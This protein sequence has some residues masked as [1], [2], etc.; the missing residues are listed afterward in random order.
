MKC[1]QAFFIVFLGL[2]LIPMVIAQQVGTPGSTGLIPKVK[3]STNIIGQTTDLTVENVASQAQRIYILIGARSWREQV[4]QFGQGAWLMVR[5]EL[6]LEMQPQGRLS[7]PVVGGLPTIYVQAAVIDPG[8]QGGIA[9]SDLFAFNIANA[10]NRR[11]GDLPQKLIGSAAAIDPRTGIMYIFG[12][13]NAYSSQ[14]PTDKII[15]M[16]P[17]QSLGH[18]VEERG[19]CPDAL[20]VPAMVWDSRRN[21]AY[22]FGGI[23]PAPLYST[24]AIYE[25]NPDTNQC[26]LLAADRLPSPRRGIT[27]VYDD[28]TGITYLLGSISASGSILTDVVAFDSSQSPGSRIRTLAVQIP[29]PILTYGFAAGRDP[30]TGIIYVLDNGGT[31]L[32]RFI[33]GGPQGGAFET[34]PNVRLPIQPTQYNPNGYLASYQGLMHPL[35]R[36]FLIVGGNTGLAP[37]GQDVAYNVRIFSFDPANPSNGF[38]EI[39]R[40]PLIVGRQDMGIAVDPVTGYVFLAGGLGRERFRYNNREL[41]DILV[42]DHSANTVSWFLSLPEPISSASI[43]R[44]PEQ[45]V[46]YLIAPR[47]VAGLTNKIIRVNEQSF[48]TTAPS[49]FDQ[50]PQ[51][52]AA[53]GAMWDARNKKIYVFGGHDASFGPVNTIY[54]ITPSNP[55]GSR[56]RAVPETLPQALKGIAVVTDSRTNKAYLFGG[57]SLTGFSTAIY[58]WD[59]QASGSRLQ[60]LSAQL[61]SGL[62]FMSGAWNPN[63]NAIYL[64]GGSG[65]T[66]SHSRQI[67]KF[68]PDTG[69][70]QV[71]ADQLP[72]G[73][74]D[75]SVVFDRDRFLIMGGDTPPGPTDEILAYNP[76]TH[77]ME[78]VGR[79][80]MVRTGLAATLVPEQALVLMFGG[81]NFGRYFDD[82]WAFS[83]GS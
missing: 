14:D 34:V 66:G 65:Y 80:G 54:E 61:P 53:T 17:R 18:E 1:F 20:N 3:V 69:Q 2:L 12:G 78:V 21:R 48:F 63:E 9:L 71:L 68:V 56:V 64:F 83:F 4:S 24:D 15:A 77:V 82:T 33:P 58:E 49:L 57:E 79:I 27:G 59:S 50:F 23:R 32:M 74:V 42:F 6:I 37:S 40:M 72:V 35:T 22:I 7:F 16:N 81:N 31:R 43:A 5:P 8:G 41:E 73:R 11:V 52:I 26:V 29:D 39:A 30:Q 38:A 51:V 25:F 47:T 76:V 67:F 70:L 46:T 28:S 19:T 75:T 45:R 10:L 62:V 44:D 36:K 55:Q 60:A 13:T